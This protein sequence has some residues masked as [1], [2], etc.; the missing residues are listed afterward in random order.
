M[1]VDFIK[2]TLI[3]ATAYVTAIEQATHEGKGDAD[4]LEC[5]RERQ[6][7][8]DQEFQYLTAKCL[9]GVQ[10]TTLKDSRFWP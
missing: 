8:A 7:Y 10:M 1:I 3:N 9:E 2:F 4:C 5:H 6:R